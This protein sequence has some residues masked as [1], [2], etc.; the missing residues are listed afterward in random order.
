MY[1]CIFRP[2]QEMRCRSQKYFYHLIYATVFACSSEVSGAELTLHKMIN[3]LVRTKRDT[4]ESSSLYSQSPSDIASSI[5]HSLFDYVDTSVFDR[6]YALFWKEY[7]LN[8]CIISKPHTT[9]YKRSRRTRLLSCL[10]RYKKPSIH[11]FYIEELRC[12]TF[13]ILLLRGNFLIIRG[14]PRIESSHK[15]A[16]HPD[17]TFYMR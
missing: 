13:G 6:V 8:L 12:I 3:R 2:I 11:N 7:D 9:I 10:H 14:N 15:C 16:T 17:E 5:Y 4:D 1:G